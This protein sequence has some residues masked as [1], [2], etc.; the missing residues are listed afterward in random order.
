MFHE[1]SIGN[2]PNPDVMCNREV[3]F[4]AFWKWAKENG[5]DYIAT[6]HYAQNINNKLL[7]GKD[8]NKD[9][10]YFLW[11]LEMYELGHILF[12]IGHLQKPELRKLAEKAKIPVFDKKDSQGVCFL[13]QIDM[14][15]FLKE[16]IET[17]K[18]DVL[19]MDGNVI[20]EHDGAVLYAIGERHGF[21]IFKNTQNQ[22][23]LYIV[24][25]DI[26]NN[27]ITVGTH[28]KMD[29]NIDKHI[30]I[31]NVVLRDSIDIIKTCRL[32][33]RQEKINIKKIVK[34]HSY[35]KVELEKP[36]MYSAGQSIV[37]YDGE[38][39]VGGGVMM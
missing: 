5:A 31:K 8:K 13:G 7:E 22:D 26:T 17:H 19:D 9:Q 4:G 38:V 16:H 2:I 15:E 27:T 32:R 29:S 23:R 1:Y 10:S 25:K 37:F 34:E 33:Y 24:K 39:C 11:T 3:K 20:G 18:G 14:K 12:P 28:V 30:L 35:Y 6:G 21:T 36:E